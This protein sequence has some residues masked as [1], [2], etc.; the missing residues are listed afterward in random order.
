[1]RQQ[2]DDY[3]IPNLKLYQDE[4]LIRQGSNLV[5]TRSI[6]WNKQDCIRIKGGLDQD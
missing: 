5:F 2:D 3:D 6:T 4:N 1:M